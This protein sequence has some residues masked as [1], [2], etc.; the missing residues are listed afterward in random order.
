MTQ[1]MTQNSV[2]STLV[3]T[4]SSGVKTGVG[5]VDSRIAAQKIWQD[6]GAGKVG[7]RITGR[8]G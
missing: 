7:L 8:A 6:F 3:G 1:V 4:P 5:G 2:L